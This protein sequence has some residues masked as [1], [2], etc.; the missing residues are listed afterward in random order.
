[1]T[2]V[3]FAQ[4]I[5]ELIGARPPRI[6][7]NKL[8]HEIQVRAKIAESRR[9][10]QQGRWITNE[11]MMEEMWEMIHSKSDGQNKLDKTSKKSSR[12]SPKTRQ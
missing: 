10:Q 9:D 3:E 6:D 11:Q 8:L 5:V 7:L 12:Q 1:M 4:K 2:T